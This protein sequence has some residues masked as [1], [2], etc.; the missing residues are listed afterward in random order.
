MNPSP[1]RDLQDFDEPPS[2]LLMEAFRYVSGDLSAAE[3]ESLESRML[4]DT[5]LCEAVVTA[6]RLGLAVSKCHGA[7]Y[8]T[9][10]AATVRDRASEE[11][12][13]AGV[14]V[15]CPTRTSHRHSAGPSARMAMVVLTFVCCFC[16]A[17]GIRMHNIRSVE[18]PVVSAAPDQAELIVTAW[19]ESF[20]AEPVE[21]F[22]EVP[23]TELAVPDW[24][25][26][27]LDMSDMSDISTDLDSVDQHPEPFENNGLEL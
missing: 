18:A 14:R 6:T 4:E 10:A 23:A 8:E 24:M 22:G 15:S 5:E 11:H 27:G 20:A 19:A 16:V 13:V 25:L 17:I 1:P 9:T 2:V 26:A 3:S 21:D 7:T 12:S